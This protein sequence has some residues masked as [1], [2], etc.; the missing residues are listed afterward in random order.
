[1]P[2]SLILINVVKVT[3]FYGSKSDPCLWKI[4][5]KRVLHMIGIYVD[6]CLIIGKAESV[7]ILIDELK[8]H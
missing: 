2:G 4:W 7:A 8:N 6:D 5:E 1:M 3:G